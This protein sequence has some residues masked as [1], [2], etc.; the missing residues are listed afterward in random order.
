MLI[1]R[2][3]H[4]QFLEEEL[5]AQTKDF[6]ETVN[7]PARYL[8][9]ERDEVYVAQLMKFEHGEMILKFSNNRGIPRKGEYLDCFSVPKEYRR[10]KD[11]GN[12][13]YRELSSKR[14]TYTEA[15][16]VWLAPAREDEESI[17][18]GAGYTL[19]GFVGIDVDF[20][21]DLSNAGKIILILG[22][23]VPPY[24]YIKN[25]QNIIRHNNTP[26][27]SEII[28]RDL[29]EAQ[30]DSVL[31]DQR[32]SAS[33]FIL[34]QM[35]L[36]DNLIL[37]GPPGTGKTYQIAQICKELCEQ[38][39][40]VLVTALTNRALIEVAEKESLAGLLEAGKVFKTKLSADEEREVKGLLPTKKLDPIPGDLILSTFYIASGEAVT[41]NSEP[42][43]DYVIMDEASQGLL[44]MFA[45]TRILG[46][47]CL[48]IGDTRQLPPVVLLNED[49]IARRGYG[50]LVDGLTTV[51][52]SGSFPSY[53]LT[54][55]YRLPERAAHFTGIFYKGTLV[56]KA[57]E[58]QR[59]TYPEIGEEA[60]KVFNP[61]GG[62]TVLQTDMSVGDGR[63]SLGIALAVA[64]V[65]KALTI[66][67][68]PKIAVFSF[69]VKTTKALQKAFAQTI[70]PNNRLLI[71]TVSR[72][73]GLTTDIVV[74]FVPNT[75]YI[76]SLDRRL[77]NVAT[78]RAKRQTIIICDRGVL[79]SYSGID[80]LVYQYLK[81]AG[82][83]SSFYISSSAEEAIKELPRIP[84]LQ[85][86]VHVSTT[87]EPKESSEKQTDGIK[88]C[89]YLDLSKF[90]KKKTYLSGDL[91]N[92]FVIDTNI[93]IKSPSIIGRIDSKHIVAIPT[94]VMD[95]LDRKK[96]F[97]DNIEVKS[98]AQNAIGKIET[99]LDNRD[100]VEIVSPDLSLL[101][102]GYDIKSPDNKILTCAM[103]YQK[104]GMNVVVV[105]ND[106]NVRTKAKGAHIKAISLSDL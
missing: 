42:Y 46:K 20:I 95:E 25:L 29:S 57:D 50:P 17:Q 40:S 67:E 13:T 106:R 32:T 10:Y 78:S 34:G 47:R 61:F 100:T 31:L 90:E 5:Q 76:R 64:I 4:A 59:L 77:F 56:S 55:T 37:E 74:Y 52:N 14:T 45:A 58:K 96:E 26:A 83:T 44:A 39:K 97:S 15:I 69:F 27:V 80:R 105:S 101:P 91:Q 9:E 87:E 7:T 48:W 18:S 94:I 93:F 38:G 30:I 84:S 79:N 1:D 35:Q 12:M 71:D 60:N 28:D 63:P 53:Q 85:L 6:I 86:P 103:H 36:C 81:E 19:V 98:R 65:A 68:R 70:G 16:C 43:F 54:Q 33:K 49:R 8:L 22:P 23:Q 82:A 66:K 75:G 11:W 102:D 2:L 88:V 99:E 41:K 92:V 21:E 62:P 3:D 73:Q 72:V 89:G 104:I 51:K 24:E